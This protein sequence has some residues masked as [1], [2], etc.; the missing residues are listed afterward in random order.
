MN[1]DYNKEKDEGYTTPMTTGLYPV[2]PV[3]DTVIFPGM[4]VTLNVG[5]ER[6]KRLLSELKPKEKIVIASLKEV[7]KGVSDPENVHKVG[8]LASVLRTIHGDDLIMLVIQGHRRVRLEEIMQNEPYFTAKVSRLDDHFLEG[9]K[10]VA[11]LVYQVKELGKIVIKQVGLPP[12]FLKSLESIKDPGALSDLV[13]SNLRIEKDKKQEILETTDVKTRLEK[14]V[15]LIMQ[16]LRKIELSKEINN[17]VN[18]EMEKSQREYYLRQQLKAIQEEL[19]GDEESD[20]DELKRRIKEADMPPDVE[21]VALKE[22]RR[23]SKIPSNSAEYTVS[24]T[25]IAWLLDMP[26]SNSTVDNEDIKEAKKTLENGHYGLEKVK[27]RILEY[28][29]VK[30]LKKEHGGPILC[31]V[32]P[33]GVGKTSIAHAVAEALDRKYV[34]I[35]LGGVHDEAEIRGH[36]RTYV[37]A[38]PGRIIQGIKKAGTFNP[39]VILDEID[40]VGYDYRGDPSSALLEVL[41]PEQNSTFSDHYLEVPFDLSRVL[42]ITTANRLDTVPAP[43]KD[44]M[45]IIEFPGYTLEEKLMIARAHLLPRQLKRHGLSEEQVTIDDEAVMAVIDGYTREAGV[46]NLERELAAILR[47]AATRIAE[48]RDQKLEISTGDLDLYLG[49][50]KFYS[51]MKKRTMA[52]GVSTGLAWTPTGGEVLFI[53]SNVMKGKKGLILTGQ[54]GDVMK[55]SAQAAL[56]YVKAHAN[57]LGIDNSLFE[58]KDIHIHV[59]AGAIPKDGP[60]AGVAMTTALISL[61]KDRPVRND[62][63]M[64]GEITLKGQVLPVGGIKE[65]ALGAQRAG[66]GTVYLPKWNE[67]DLYD[68]PEEIRSKMKFR[69]IERVDEIVDEAFGDIR[70]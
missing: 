44:R 30:K 28:L 54:L 53:E 63:A 49:P 1:S 17:K 19:D 22:L 35:S 21:A 29:A 58:G 65:K 62:I 15:P 27:K 6:S 5:E 55:E 31:F 25:Y 10:K 38:L 59:P 61:F 68:I 13:A 64:T 2:L 26:W 67:K 24:R 56:S 57:D 12:E 47:G 51:E 69:F 70:N 8:I 9:D 45:E 23:L 3:K 46:R 7:E 16:D 40:K 66:I 34:R 60:S 33:P 11:D 4:A 43:L 52:P 39:V 36:R 41:D 50:K 48:D 14:I 37:G 20:A 32:G 18:Q 42:F